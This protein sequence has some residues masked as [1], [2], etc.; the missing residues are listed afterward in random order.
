MDTTDH[1][2]PALWCPIAPALHP[3]WKLWDSNAIHWIS[4]FGI[5]GRKS[6][7]V[8]LR[9]LR[10]G[11]LAGRTATTAED[12]CRAQFSAD[13]LM[14]LFAFD[15]ACCDEGRHSHDPVTMA[16]LIAD[17]TRIA[18]TGRAG[19]AGPL[20]YALA[21]LRQRLD[22]MA[23]FA[24][25]ARWVRAMKAY[26]AYQVWEAA[27]R[28]IDA[29]PTVDQYAVARIRNGSMEVCVMT[30]DIAEGYEVPADEIDRPDVRALT[31]MACDVVGW[32]NDIASYY[33]EHKRTGDKLNMIDVMAHERQETSQAALSDA[34]GLRNRVLALYL[35][36]HDET[37][38][39]VS[40]ATVR[41]LHGLSAWIRGNLDWSIGTARYRKHDRPTIQ[42]T[43]V[44]PVI[45]SLPPP[46]GIAWWWDQV[47][48]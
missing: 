43:A 20:G 46:P 10:A 22:G 26:L 38:P 11:E 31:E 27:Y 35:Q 18:E 15:D 13:S 25:T 6:G 3:D 47:Q 37:K 23:S 36:L 40:R 45:P 5:D 44:P 32:D 1:D 39:R 19:P 48:H 17:M 7:T 42:V 8:R 29:V 34:V 33:K 9:G 21:D 14:W 16:I 41:Y 24:Q 2:M 30:L 4:R 12:Q 28:N